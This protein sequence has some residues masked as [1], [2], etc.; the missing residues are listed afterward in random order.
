LGSKAT[1]QED[2]PDRLAMKMAKI[3]VWE[4]D[5]VN[6]NVNYSNEW[7]TLRSCCE[8]DVG[9]SIEELYRRVHPDDLSDLQTEFDRLFRGKVNEVEI[10]H[11]VQQVDNQWIWICERVCAVCDANGKPL[12]LIGCDIE[13]TDRVQAEIAYEISESRYTSI[14]NN[15]PIAVCQFESD[16]GCTYVSSHWSHLA[17]RPSES[18]LGDGWVETVHPDFRERALDFYE[19]GKKG[20]P[21][22]ERVF[23]GTETQLYRPDGTVKWVLSTVRVKYDQNGNRSAS[24][25]VMIDIDDRKSIEQALL[26]SERKYSSLAASSPTA[27]FRFDSPTNCI[28]VNQRWSEFTQRPIESALGEGW[29]DAIHP[30]DLQSAMKLGQT[31]TEDP[32]QNIS[33][34]LQARHLLPDGSIQWVQTQVV[35]ELGEN[36]EI[37]GLVGTLN[38]IT[39]LKK[40]EEDLKTVTDRL[41]AVLNCSSIGIWERCWKTEEFIWNEQMIKIH[42]IEAADFRGT[43]QDWS[44]RLH[45]DDFDRMTKAEKS[46]LKNDASAATEYKIVRPNGQIRHIYSNVY[47]EV[48]EQGEPVRT[49]GINMDITD[50]RHAELALLESET[51]FMRVAENVPGMVFRL[52]VR[53]DQSHSLTY[54]NSRVREIFELEPDDVIRNT[55]SMESRIHP[56]DLEPL[57]RSVM[58]S[59]K[60]LEPLQCEFRL[61]LPDKGLRWVHSYAHPVKIKNGDTVWDGLVVDKTDPKLDQLALQNS[62]AQFARMTENVPGMIFQFKLCADGSNKL[63]YVSSKSLELL[64]VS[65]E[66]ALK[67]PNELWSRVHP[68]DRSRIES[69]VLKSAKTLTPTNEECR[70]VLPNESI[71]WIQ[72]ISH[73]EKTESGD[74]VWDGVALDITDRKEVELANDVLAKATKTKDEFLATMSHELRTPLTAILA[75]TDVLQQDIFGPLNFRQQESLSTIERSGTHLLDLINEVLDLAKI[76]AGQLELDVTNVNVSELCESSLQFVR[77][78]AE[79]KKIQLNLRVQWNL[80]EFEADEK[81][82]RQVLINLLNN[83]VKFTPNGGEVVLEVNKLTAQT[84][85]NRPDNQTEDVLQISVSDN[86]IGIEA[87]QLDSLFQPFVQVDS[88]LSRNYEGTGLGLSLVK[89]FVELHDGKISVQSQPG[90][91]SC[92]TV[93]LPFHQSKPHQ[94]HELETSDSALPNNEGKPYADDKPLAKTNKNLAETKPPVVLIAEDNEEVAMAVEIFLKAANFK[95]VHVVNGELALESARDL[96]PDVILM[97]IQMPKMDGLEAIRLIRAIPELKVTPIIAFS[98]FAMQEDSNRCIAAG[99][100]YFMSKPY[101]MKDLVNKIRSVVPNQSVAS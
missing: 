34:P 70:I 61:E 95:V 43:L 7:K 71:R 65:P 45:P 37:V 89:Q 11:R 39:A 62:Q 13:I 57:A 19:L 17:G 29:M 35:K 97:D 50:R 24:T 40:A 36:G 33:E 69:A 58:F 66:N 27:I 72:A 9:N 26:A 51:K 75:M 59:A 52:V 83:A 78:H 22:Q 20:P 10:E 14:I 98:G 1:L 76:G 8:I 38:D 79:K 99:A 32:S 16:K 28:Y 12:R 53:P 5:L 54:V 92:F 93:D 80:P 30:D 63:T 2:S 84:S 31:F 73:P 94:P 96:S 67:N 4:W 23:E 60:H 68:E 49:I 3:G 88:S 82:I 41:Y 18:A 64:G 48:D 21:N 25:L 47:I 87:N 56:D 100:D 86:G 6:Q 44:D 101:R 77:H 85:L 46:R 90:A 74:I 81:R 55:D 15:L 42:G 91:G